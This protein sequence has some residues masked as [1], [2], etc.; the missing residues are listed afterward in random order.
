MSTTS[1]E[2]S[3][4]SAE[5]R[6]VVHEALLYVSE[7]APAIG[8]RVLEGMSAKEIARNLFANMRSSLS[9]PAMFAAL[10]V[11]RR[12]QILVHETGESFS[13][14]D[15]EFNESTMKRCSVNYTTQ[16]I[17]KTLIERMYLKFWNS[18]ENSDPNFNPYFDVSKALDKIISYTAKK[19]FGIK[20]D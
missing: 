13:A 2:K 16:C 5:T 8:D 18:L 6:I 7:I 1:T 14:G 3:T 20:I 17:A 4:S 11:M 19:Q 10:R 9:I 15:V 12:L